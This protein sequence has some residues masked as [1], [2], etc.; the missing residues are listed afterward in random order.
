MSASCEV[1]IIVFET[2]Y[3][4]SPSN[5]VRK[6]GSPS[7]RAPTL[8]A[9]P[10]V[11]PLLPVPQPPPPPHLSPPLPLTQFSTP[12]RNR[13]PRLYLPDVLAVK[14]SRTGSSSAPPHLRAG[15][16]RLVISRDPV[17][18]LRVV[19]SPMS[20]AARGRRRLLT[21]ASTARTPRVKVRPC[22]LSP[23]SPS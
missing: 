10:P 7:L 23:A 17:Q 21:T 13:S 3:R 19:L 14:T 18:P 9:P 8:L 1:A 5:G 15:R 16:H 2:M 12:S 11:S 20:L 4:E 6:N 22:R